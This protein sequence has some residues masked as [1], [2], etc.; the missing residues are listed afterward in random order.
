MQLSV[1]AAA[2]VLAGGDVEAA[3]LPAGQVA[4]VVAQGE[5]C[6]VPQVPG[7]ALLGRF[8][9]QAVSADRGR[10]ASGEVEPALGVAGQDARSLPLVHA[11]APSELGAVALLAVLGLDLAVPAAPA[12]RR[13]VH[14]TIARA[15]D[16]ARGRVIA[17]LL[18][19]PRGEVV[20]VARLA[21]VDEAVPAGFFHFHRGVAGTDQEDQTQEGHEGAA[22]E[23]YRWLHVTG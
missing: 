10:S 7:L 3:V 15:H 17:E 20:A 12:A 5:A 1:A 18:A 14:L 16:R 4:A 21:R 6:L 22:L 23:H 2:G 8:G 19:I 11:R 13:E 9:D